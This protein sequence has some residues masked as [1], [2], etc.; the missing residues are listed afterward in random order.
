MC[1]FHSRQFKQTLNLQKR[2]YSLS[3][4]CVLFVLIGLLYLERLSGQDSSFKAPSFDVVT[5]L[6]VNLNQGLKLPNQEERHALLKKLG[7]EFGQVD[8]T[9][10][11]ALVDTEFRSV[12]DKETF[13][14]ALLNQW[15]R[16]KPEAAL[17][18]CSDLPEGEGRL[19]AYTAALI[20]WSK[21]DPKASSQ[22]VFVHL[23]TIYRRTAAGAVGR[24]WVAEN[25]EEA[26]RWAAAWPNELER[27]F[28]LGEVLETWGLDYGPEA[29]NW[30]AKM[31]P[32]KLRDL[33]MSKV[34]FRWGENYPKTAS[35]WLV[36]NPDHNWLLPRVIAKWAKYDQVAA[37]SWLE[38]LTNEDLATE[39]K[40]A[41]V[42]EWAQYNP[43]SAYDWIRVKLKDDTQALAINEVLQTWAQEYP[44]EALDWI[45]EAVPV[46]ERI[47]AL[48]IILQTWSMIDKEHFNSWL[49]Q[50]NPGL[51]KDLGLEQMARM[52]INADPEAAMKAARLISNP[53]RQ[54][55]VSSE[56]FEQ[57]KA[58]APDEA[59]K[60]K[61]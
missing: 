38:L 37:S 23:K 42:A 15:A 2:W 31:D 47:Q 1:K 10:G 5:Q 8:P 13:L 36:N 12:F 17:K 52:L 45:K 58:R 60:W 35:E 59:A 24:T 11:W 26:A 54:Q 6:E 49:G 30:V 53:V 39:C 21:V 19:L 28:I 18:A 29:A 46:P 48:E 56:L 20:G 22:W 43:R 16:N 33:M 7:V 14:M 44:K 51:E 34:M 57:W 41:L 3:G 61:P 55:T 50:Q 25:P 4:S 9:R 32:G 27:I 40:V